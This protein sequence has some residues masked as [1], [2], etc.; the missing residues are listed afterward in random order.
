ME[1]LSELARYPCPNYCACCFIPCPQEFM[2]QILICAMVVIYVI[3]S[4]IEYYLFLLFY[5]FLFSCKLKYF[6][7]VFL[8]NP[9]ANVNVVIVPA[10]PVA[11][12]VVNVVVVVNVALKRK[13]KLF[14]L[15][16][17]IMN[18]MMFV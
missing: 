13:K 8:A 3:G 2:S 9:V 4:A 6:L 15:I 14:P 7:A 10:V 16:N 18:K 11:P 1:Y 5:M 17:K 12:V